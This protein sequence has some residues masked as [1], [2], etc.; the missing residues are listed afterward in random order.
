[1]A[2]QQNGRRILLKRAKSLHLVPYVYNSTYDDYVLGSDVY[3]LSA[4]VGDSMQLQQGDGNT[5]SED[6]EFTNQPLVQ[7]VTA[8]RYA[9]TAQCVDLQNNMVKVIFGAMT[10]AGVDGLF[11][12]PD[13]YHD[14]FVLVRVAFKDA[15][16]PDMII[17]KLNL[18]STLIVSQL[19][20]QLSKGTLGGTAFN[21]MV[22]YA[23]GVATINLLTTTQP[24]EQFSVPATGG[25]TYT[26]VTPVIFTP[27]A[28]SLYVLHHYDEQ[29]DKYT[30][31]KIAWSSGSITNNH[32]MNNGA[33]QIITTSGL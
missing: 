11:A 33:S 17:P 9:F 6:N 8:G 26:P 19:K 30:F 5:D 13:D 22:A 27:N 25:T 24:V 7:C 21:R 20:S 12:M 28:N 15:N 10:G 4:I 32:T 2:N 29:A 1:M 3:D 23:N 31:S 18:N 16:A 14:M